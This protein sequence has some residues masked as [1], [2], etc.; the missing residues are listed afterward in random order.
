M[1]FPPEQ[2]TT[3]DK[4]HGRI[5]VRTITI[6]PVKPGQISFPFAHQVFSVERNFSDFAGQLLSSEKVFGVTSLTQEKA[7]PDR[8]LAL[9]RGHWAIENKVHHVRDVTMSEDASRIRKGGGPRLMAI[10]RNLVLSQLRQAGITNIAEKILRFALDK[11]SLFKFAGIR[12]A[13]KN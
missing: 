2:V 11:N 7:G 1:L 13:I 5:E 10:F 3:T 8:V 6:L 4:G 9:N 12:G